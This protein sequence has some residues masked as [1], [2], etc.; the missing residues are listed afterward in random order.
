MHL[1]LFIS[2]PQFWK[3]SISIIFADWLTKWGLKFQYKCFWSSQSKTKLTSFI[4]FSEAA[5]TTMIFFV[6]SLIFFYLA[7][8]FDLI[9]LMINHFI[10]ETELIVTWL[11][12]SFA[13]IPLF[14]IRVCCFSMT[15]HHFEYGFDIICYYLWLSCL[16][17][18]KIY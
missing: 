6:V 8:H 14:F 4:C 13:T 18:N 1:A 16:A 15:A 12:A 5:S 2:Q 9:Y 10:F 3:W 17:M 11:F 7:D